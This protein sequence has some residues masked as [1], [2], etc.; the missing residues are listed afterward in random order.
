MDALVPLLD[1]LVLVPATFS[2]HTILM[3]RNGL[4]DRHDVSPRDLYNQASH[5]K[6]FFAVGGYASYCS[7]ATCCET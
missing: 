4:I 7:Y 2:F 6:I 3:L 1:Q 5:Q